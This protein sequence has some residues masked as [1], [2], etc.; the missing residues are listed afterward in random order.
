MAG[1]Y[2]FK[3][4]FSQALEKLKLQIYQTASMLC[5]CQTSGY[6]PEVKELSTSAH[7]STL[8]LDNHPLH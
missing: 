7:L 5:Y 6:I 1:L 4:L 2:F 8:T 3:Y